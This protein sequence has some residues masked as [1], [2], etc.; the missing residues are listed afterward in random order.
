ML[1]FAGLPDPS[2][3]RTEHIPFGDSTIIIHA[4][5]RQAAYARHTAPLSMKTTLC[6]EERYAV[7]GFFQT[8]A[9]DRFLL[10]NE[11]EP[12]ASILDADRP[13]ETCCVF[14]SRQDRA[15][16]ARALQP[17]DAAVDGSLASKFEVGFH[18]DLRAK[19]NAVARAIADLLRARREPRMA[20][21]EARARLMRR[22]IESEQ[23]HRAAEAAGPARKRSTR[24]DLYRRCV[25][26][27][28]RIRSEYD[29][30][31]TVEALAGHAGLSRTHFLRAFVH[32]FGE[33]P[34]QCLK[35]VRLEEAARRLRGS[36]VSVGE[37]ALA[38]GYEDFSA[39]AR[40]F[41]AVFGVPPSRFR[42]T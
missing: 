35:R 8:V 24:A 26:A 23:G 5:A 27:R 30:D 18:T 12:Y 21:E 25:I 16:F 17:L 33:T 9:S 34:H 36:A 13:V 28:E 7:N 20:Q 32:A 22:L 41:R 31:L 42:D 37:V 40:S 14:F 19:S 6:G 29:R 15:E 39:F 11:A 38:V 2:N 4:I 3:P 1:V 10:I